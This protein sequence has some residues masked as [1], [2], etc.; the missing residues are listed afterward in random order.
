MKKKVFMGIFLILILIAN[1]SLAS[2][3]TVTMEV[4]EEPV[5]TIEIG[6]NS[7]FEKQLVE[8]NLN[9]KEVTLELKVTNGESTLQPTGELVIVIDNSDSMNNE[10][11]EGTV[12]KDLVY[13][14][15]ET[16]LNK[17]LEN[18]NDLKVSIVSFSSST[19]I[20]E[21]ATLADATLVSPLSSDLT[22]LTNALSNIE[23]TGPRTDLDAGLTL[24]M[25]QFTEDAT[26]KYMIVLT[27]G[28]PNLAL[29]YDKVYYSDDVIN[30]TNEKLKS[31]EANNIKL[32]TML[33]GINDE[34]YTPPT[35]SKNFGQII[36]EIFG[37]PDKPT[38]GTFFYVTDDEVETTI[39]NDIYNSLLPIS[40]SLKNIKVVDYFPQ[41]IIDNF[42]FAYVTEASIGDISAEVDKTNNS[43]T[44]TIPEL[45]SGETTTVKY[46]LKLKENF[47]Q[48][49]VDKIL[50]T[51]E[52]VDISY[53]DFNGETQNKTS[54]VTPKL[55]LSEP[56]AVLPK[57]GTITLIGFATLAIGL[58]GYSL[59]RLTILNKQ[60]K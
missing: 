38:A 58:F 56:P 44:W 46:K 25:Q 23:A 31:I 4:V 5:C 28:V 41:E 1:I 52:K 37:T 15:A 29:D 30:K 34:D 26:N 60:M 16:L 53:D 12:R 47:S 54:D 59:I 40:Q 39:T 21:E 2:Y 42:D 50:D 35:T 9:N 3:S 19:E 32:F 55:K 17:A 24:G 7:K 20:S 13:K 27:D 57:A 11:S 14:S 49:I 48:E 6:E 45:K 10:V 18:N 8:K 33:T 22:S 43:I 51:N 36:N